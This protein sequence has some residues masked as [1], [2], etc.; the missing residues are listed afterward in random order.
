VITSVT[1]TQVSGTACAN[2]TIEIFSD[3][4]GEGAIYEGTTTADASGNWVFT[5]PGG[6]TGPNVTATATDGKGNTSE[7][8]APVN[9]L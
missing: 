5:K 8:L 6:L 2:C 4:N 3:A 9:V 1:A 7:F